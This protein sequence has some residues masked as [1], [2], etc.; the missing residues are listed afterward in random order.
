MATRV[1]SSSIETITFNYG[2]KHNDREN[3]AAKKICSAYGI[4]NTLVRLPFIN[5]LFASDLLKSGG[6]VPDGHYEDQA[7]KRTVVPFRNGIMLAI[8]VGYAE[9]IGAKRV[10]LG[11]HAGDHAIYPDCR[12]DF[13]AAIAEAARLGTY[14][15]VQIVTPFVSMT[16][17]QI[18]ALGQTLGTPLS[19]T[20]SCYKGGESHCG[21]CGTC[22][23]RMEAFF[24][25]GVPDPTSYLGDA[26]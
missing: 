2:S 20:Y 24:N 11:N 17:A 6:D 10:Y 14:L 5:D 23:E 1:L 19:N 15:G 21:T 22:V 25:A 3:L 16:K 9:S 4:K 26:S 7:M 12:A 18:C 13:S 8:A